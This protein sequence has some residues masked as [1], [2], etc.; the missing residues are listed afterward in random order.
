MIQKL[1]QHNSLS[2][3]IYLFFRSYKKAKTY[4]YL[5]TLSYVTHD[6]TRNNPV[7]FQWQI[8][9]WDP[10]KFILDQCIA[11]KKSETKNIK[12]PPQ[13]KKIIRSINFSK[14]NE[15]NAEV[16]TLGEAIVLHFEKEVLMRANKKELADKVA[17]TKIF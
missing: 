15:R 14:M 2:H 11:N 9:D 7:Y 6:K 3:N 1:I 8:H 5:G 12:N 10:P 16:G 17:L 4:T 13:P